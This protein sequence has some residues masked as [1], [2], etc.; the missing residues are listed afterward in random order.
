MPPDYAQQG[1][2]P[3]SP[4]TMPADP[5]LRAWRT[6]AVTRERL[7]AAVFAVRTARAGLLEAHAATRAARAELQAARARQAEEINLALELDGWTPER[8]AEVLGVSRQQVVQL[9][10]VRAG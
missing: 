7:L 6:D 3:T 5:E 1:S 9:R 10:K 2:R 4:T 8:V